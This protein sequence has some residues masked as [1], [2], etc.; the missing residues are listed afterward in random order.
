VTAG[1]T[2]CA[3]NVVPGGTFD[4]SNDPSYPATVSSF[5]L[6]TYEI[7]VGRFRAFVAAGGGT[8]ASP[9]VVGSGANPHL[10]GSGWL[11]VWSLNLPADTSA[12]TA[13][14]KCSSSLQTWTDAPGSNED[15]PM[16]CI[17]WYE[18]FAFC[19]WDG[20]RLPSE[21]EWNYAAAGGSEQRSY[22][23]GA[24]T[25]D[26]AH[27]VYCGGACSSMADVGSKSTAGDGKWG[28]ADL[29][30]NLWEWVFDRFGT[31][32]T[33]CNDCALIAT[34]ANRVVRGGSFSDDA[35]WLASS[36]RSYGDLPMSRYVTLGARCAR[37]P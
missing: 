5:G 36:N 18:A 13:A 1:E 20:G 37:N 31:Y 33:P 8:Q 2:C 19:I 34:G 21:A 22:P 7:T 4:R 11:A 32:V 10:A 27:A 24:A 28:Q 6:D 12:L 9:P 16:N 3:W 23:W 30:G 14:V 26:D 29:A 17:S 25:P 15:R 35:S